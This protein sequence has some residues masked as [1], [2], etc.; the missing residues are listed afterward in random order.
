MPT[1]ANIQAATL[2]KFIEGWKEWTPEG[3][4][5]TFSDD[6]QQ[7]ILPLSLGLP[8]R[9]RAETVQFL[10]TITGVVKNFQV[11]IHD[12]VHDSAKGKA[13][14]RATSNADTPFGDFKWKNEHF[15][16][17][18]F[19]EDGEHVCKMEE[20]MDSAFCR[21]FFPRLHSYMSEERA[22]G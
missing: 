15:I 12:I 13:V 2:E 8:P 14:I 6:F 21:E 18:T 11:K 20:M 4:A 1:T 7:Q 19:T 16:L 17:L 10:P 22:S 5:A 9:S 3:C